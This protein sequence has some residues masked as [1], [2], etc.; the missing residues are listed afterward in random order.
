MKSSNGLDNS[1]G[2]VYNRTSDEREEDLCVR[3]QSGDADAEEQLIERYSR[4]V[5]AVAR[6]YF[7]SG[8]DFED[9]IQEGML[10]LLSAVREYTPE[11]GASFRTF[12][13]VCVR[14]RVYSALRKAAR[15]KNSPL[16]NSVPLEAP[17]FDGAAPLGDGA[18]TPEELVLGAERTRE[19]ME[20]LAGILSGFEAEV[21]DFY[22]QGLSYEEIGRLTGKD[23]KA[24]D[25]AV[26]RIRRKLSRHLL[27]SGDSR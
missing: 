27:N 7:L 8:G 6:P 16:N 14:R 9:L 22:L 12:A 11:R 3:A 24:V 20:T 15:E 17:F 26:Q 2:D 1:G 21:L 18:V 5:R 25:N 19:F 13:E 23:A 10:G 4:L